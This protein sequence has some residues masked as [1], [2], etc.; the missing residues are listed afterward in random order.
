MT[1]PE[2]I[3]A[4][5]DH[6]FELAMGELKTGDGDRR[7]LRL[8]SA[9]VLQALAEVP[10]Q[11]VTKAELM[12]RVWKDTYVTDDSLVQCVSEIR[13]ALGP[14]DGKLLVTVPKRG[15]RLDA[16]VGGAGA[17]VAKSA[18]RRGRAVSVLAGLVVVTLALA[19]TF[20]LLRPT[21]DTGAPETLAVMP[22]RTIGGEGPD[23]FSAGVAEDLIV[24]LSA[25]SDLRVLASSITF[26]STAR[27][28]DLRD[29]AAT[30]GADFVLDGSVRRQDGDLRVTAALI[31]AKSGANVWA[32]SYE[33]AAEDIFV[34]QDQVLQALVRTLSVRLSR[35]ERARLGIRGTTSIAAHDAYLRARELENLYTPD[36]NLGAEAYL[37]AALR[38]DP[39]FALAHAHLAQVM[40]FRV[41][42]GWSD[43]PERDIE[44]AFE[45]ARRAV[46][47]DPELPFA[48]FSLGRLYTRSYSH[49]MDLA[50]A[51]YRSA[52][53]LDANYVDA[54]MFLANVLIFDGRAEEA[55]PLI[56]EAFER[57]PIPPFWYYQA[58]GMA[59]YFLEDYARAEAALVTARD[60]NPT[61]PFPYRFLIA[62]YGQMD[63]LDD[64]DWMA[65]E[66]EALGRVATVEDLLASASIADPGYREHF[67]EG[68]RKAGLPES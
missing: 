44:T 2:Q 33:G 67:A 54:Y 40:S 56:A 35:A 18:A 28:S 12:E 20:W 37:R 8:Q 1:K 60:Q 3:L 46:A 24:S 63:N 17:A 21:P 29:F 32:D 38:L 4:I 66:Y 13:K 25:L 68:F 22:F 64:A 27:G 26:S 7:P 65:M 62:T 41:E 42:N 47:L 5:G 53:A 23:Y 57:N 6:L 15:Y 61:A 10:G 39:D 36:T 16:G 55:L 51:A 11:V 30:I 59:A 45:A 31:D 14:E 19:A 49:E 58:E 52:V 48:H 9:S 34:F 43:A 50:E